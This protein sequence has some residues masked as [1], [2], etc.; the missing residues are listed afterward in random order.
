MKPYPI[1]FR[2]WQGTAIRAEGHWWLSPRQLS[3]HLNL[4][5]TS[6]QRKIYDGDFKAG[7]LIMGVPGQ[8]QMRPTL[9]LKLGYFG[10]WM[11]SINTGKVP[12][13]KRAALLAM[14]VSLLDALDRQLQAMF[15]LPGSLE[16]ED[17]VHLPMPLWHEKDAMPDTVWRLREVELDRP[18]TLQ[19]VRLARLGL[20]GSKI[21]PALG[22]SPYWARKE[23]RWHVQIGLVPPNKREEQRLIGL[24]QPDLFGA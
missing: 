13:E 6:Q 1:I 4:N 18:D 2:D 14:K 15:A 20:P 7:A 12:E 22:R 9:M 17:L 24:R 16:V 5:W 23:R 3:D 19:A 10:A 11:L 21:G 8:D